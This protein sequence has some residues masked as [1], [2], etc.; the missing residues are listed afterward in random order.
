M[1]PL[2][3]TA[4]H[5]VHTPTL[6]GLGERAHLAHSGI[7]PDLHVK[8]ILG[9]IRFS[10]LTDVVLVGH[11]YGGVVTTGV[12]FEIPERIRSLVYLDALVPE[13]SGQ[14]AFDVALA[15]RR[16][17]IL[18]SAG[19]GFLI[20]PSGLHRWSA[21]PETLEWLSGLVTPHPIRCFSEGPT[22]SG[23][24]NEV[25]KRMFILCAANSPSS[26]WKFHDK[27]QSDPSWRTEKLDCLHDAMLELPKDV[28]WL[29]DEMA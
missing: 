17:E 9:V 13:R 1:V 4:G 15:A 21:D 25:G 10:E 12:A 6:T 8:D 23:R 29:I 28:A 16:R 7:N 27:F 26:F 18:E 14:A 3:R 20:P 5:E 2:L 19:S 24:Q 22:L 11:S